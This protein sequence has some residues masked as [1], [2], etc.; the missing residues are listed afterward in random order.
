MLDEL[1]AAGDLV[2]T[3]A[4]ALGADDGRVRLFFRDR[5][6]LLASSVVL[7]E[8]PD[9]PLHDA[10]REQLTR[11]GASFWPDLVGAAGGADEAVLLTALWD[12]VWAG[13]ITND[14]F[15]PLRAPPRVRRARRARARPHPG[16]LTRLGPPAGAGRWSLV[17]HLL[18]PAP[19]P[20]EMAH[21]TALQ[22]LE[23]HGVVTREAV[24]AEG[25]PGGFAGVYPGAARARRVGRAR[26]GWFVAGLGA[27]QF[28]LPGAVD[29]LRAHR[30]P[31]A[32]EPGRVVVL[33]ATDP[34]QPYGAALG[35]PEHAGASRPTRAA[36]AHVV[37]VDGECVAYLERGGR[38]LLTFRARR[39]RRR[40]RRCG[41]TRSSRRT[42]KAGSA[43]CRSS[44]STTSRPRTSAHA[45]LPAAA[46]F[47]D[48]YKGLTLHK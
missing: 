27:A 38:T 17:A 44:A 30:H 7:P 8:P 40:S 35:W 10:I 15:G 18:D 6:K 24:R 11:A 14:T 19:T 1:C 12:L 13:E 46:G 31:P 22:L 23:R 47:A 42:R 21:A 26:R 34:A 29:R 20:T 37:L 41:S 9:G 4:G 36:G 33:A 45:P 5:V 3:G 16:R 2:W 28:A 32:D 39:H 25:T 48:G 43:G